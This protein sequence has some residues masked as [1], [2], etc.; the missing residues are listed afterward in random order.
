MHLARDTIRIQ[1]MR[2]LTSKILAPPF[3][4]IADC[5]FNNRFPGDVD[6]VLSVTTNLQN[7]YLLVLASKAYS[8]VC[9]KPNNSFFFEVSLSAS[10]THR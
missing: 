2:D 7:N 1:Q 6:R 5:I 8:L 10:N 4:N 3:K 9:R